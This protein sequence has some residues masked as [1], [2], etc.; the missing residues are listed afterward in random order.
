MSQMSK[1]IVIVLLTILFM[2]NGGGLN[3]KERYDEADLYRLFDVE[4]VGANLVVVVDTSLSMKNDFPPVTKAL[5]SFSKILQPSDQLTVITFDNQAKVVYRGSAGAGEKIRKA[6]PKTP[7]PK[8]NRTDM[9]VAVNQVLEELK[10]GGDKLPVVV[11]MTDGA[12]DPPP[13]SLFATEHDKA[14]GKLKDRANNEPVAKDAYVHGIGFNKNTD[15]DMLKQVWPRTQPLTLNPS[16]LSVYFVGLKEKIRKERLRLELSKELEQGKIKIKAV[17]PNWGGIRSGTNFSRYFTVTSS[18]KKLPV[19]IKT[20]GAVWSEFESITKQKSLES[21]LP[22]FRVKSEIIRLEPGQSR[23]LALNVKVPKLKGKLGLKSQ[24]KYRGNIAFDV[25]GKTPYAASLRTFGAEPRIEVQGADQTIWFNRPVGQSLYL[26]LALALA[27]MAT[28]VIFWRRAVTPA[29]MLVY[30]HIWAPQL[31]GRFAFSGAPTGTPLPKPLDLQQ[32]GRRTIIGSS[33]RVKLSGPD[34][35]EKHAEIFTK[36]EAGAPEVVIKQCEGEVRVAK[37]S[38]SVP[39]RITEPTPL[40]A[41]NIIQ[42]GDYRIQ[43]I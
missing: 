41:G 28:V 2:I 13:K 4:K 6:L 36:W 27:G 30:R 12:E 35:K 3:A 1:R 26:L 37:T 21:R 16:E 7:N 10:A 18:Y 31:F 42:V 34:I 39:V 20:T 23:R 19:E 33:G 11:F 29:G 5:K 43:W 38:T 17:N 22:G 25:A 32:F 40:K 8:G 24:E 14:W 15:I 9:G